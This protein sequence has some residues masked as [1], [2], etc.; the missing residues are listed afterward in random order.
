MIILCC[1]L[2][3]VNCFKKWNTEIY[4]NSHN[5]YQEYKD[6]DLLF[7]ENYDDSMFFRKIDPMDEAREV[8]EN[9][10]DSVLNCFGIGGR[11]ST[12]LDSYLR[13][14]ANGTEALKVLFYSTSRKQSKRVTMRHGDLFLLDETDFDIKR[15]TIFIVHGFF[16]D[17]NEQWI[18]DMEKALLKWVSVHI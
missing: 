15:R 7:D 3:S 16:S 13:K 12:M 5:V 1:V 8:D 2:S 9:N 11:L 14:D 10:S 6:E 4:E 18:I 17:G